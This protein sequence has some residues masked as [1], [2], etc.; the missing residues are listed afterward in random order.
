MAFSQ[1]FDPTKGY[2]A[3]PCDV[4][5]IEMSPGSFRLLVELCRMANRSGECWPSL[6]QLS[7]RIGRSKA[8]ISGYIAELR[9]L[10]LVETVNQK[11]ANGYNYRLKYSVTF[12]AEWRAK[13]S[14]PRLVSNVSET[15]RSVQPDERRVN[16]KNQNH[17]NNTSENSEPTDTESPQLVSVFSK[18][19]DLS[20]AAPFPTFNA[21]VPENLLRE[22]QTVLANVALKI[23][24]EAEVAQSLSGL[25]K[26]LG[27][28]ISILE[29][30]QQVKAFKA[31]QTTK[32]G[33]TVFENEVKSQWK[34]HWRKPPNETQFSAMLAA[35]QKKNRTEG[36]LRMLEQYLRRWELLQK[37]LQPSRTSPNLALKH[38]A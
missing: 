3:L 33:M 13:L 2:V 37:Q 29:V 20:K 15:E 17:K 36:M 24:S 16:S 8:A 25:W 1:D 9:A 32:L 28:S 21:E 38:A 7:E 22:T 19:S 30:E 35:A 14:A 5:D 6:G 34:D 12:W 11:M 27:V 23:L 10:D 26:G 18:W 4:M 31:R